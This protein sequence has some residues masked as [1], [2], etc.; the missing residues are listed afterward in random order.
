MAKPPPLTN[1]LNWWS[2]RAQWRRLIRDLEVFPGIHVWRQDG[3]TWIDV[4]MRRPYLGFGSGHRYRFTTMPL[5]LDPQGYPDTTL[6]DNV[7][8][9]AA[10]PRRRALYCWDERHQLVMAA[11]TFHVDRLSSVPVVITDFALREDD[12]HLASRFATAMLLD[13]LLDVAM[14]APNRVADHEVGFLAPGAH[15]RSEAQGLGLTPC[16]KPSA[17][18]KP[19]TWFCHRRVRPRPGLQVLIARQVSRR[20]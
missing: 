14:I 4:E 9:D 5:P 2:L 8:H 1:G 3:K 12:L 11:I 20:R 6:R 18:S 17:L 13:V 16:P 7:A 10:K 15:Q 19:G